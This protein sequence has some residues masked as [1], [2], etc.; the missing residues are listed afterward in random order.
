MATYAIQ[1]TSRAA[2]QIRRVSSWWQQNR[3]AAPGAV[4]AELTR[5]FALLASRPDLGTL[6]S[7]VKLAGVRRIHLPRIHHHLYYRVQANAVVV[8]ALWHTSRGSAPP[9][10]TERGA[11][12]GWVV[13]EEAVDAGGDV[14]FHFGD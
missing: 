8:L 11:A 2:A 12:E 9:P 5:I 7:N 1:V 14:A 4:Q 10:L 6:A 3:Q 13:G